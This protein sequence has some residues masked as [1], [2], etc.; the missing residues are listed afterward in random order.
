ME[1]YEKPVMELM[2]F[3]SDIIATSGGEPTADP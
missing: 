1:N 2:E 3:Q